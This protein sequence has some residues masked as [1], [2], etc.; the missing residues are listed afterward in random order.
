MT[1]SPA[2]RKHRQ[3]AAH[4]G[5]SSGPKEALSGSDSDNF[6]ERLKDD[7]LNAIAEHNRVIV[8]V[9]DVSYR[10]KNSA[11]SLCEVIAGLV[12]KVLNEMYI[13]EL[14]IE[15]GSTASAIVRRLGW[16]RF[17][18]CREPLPGVVRM[19]VNAEQER[20]ITIKPGSYIWP[21]TV[22]NKFNLTHL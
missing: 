15:G 19:R 7:I 22:L 14:L 2:L 18:P 17:T 3:P 11:D 10:T 21:D 16:K 12:E 6:A 1:I 4:I 20:F 5:E 9:N 13:P 8:A